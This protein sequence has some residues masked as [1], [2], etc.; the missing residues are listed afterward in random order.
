M[1]LHLTNM[2]VNKGDISDNSTGHSETEDSPDARLG[3]NLTSDSNVTSTAITSSH[4]DY[5]VV[6]SDQEENDP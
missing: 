6:L 2:H 4:A 5:E 3:D 1:I